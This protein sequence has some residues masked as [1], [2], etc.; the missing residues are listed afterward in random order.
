MCSPNLEAL[1]INC[2]L[3]YSPREFSSFIPV[4]VYVPPDACVSTAMQQ[5]AE[6]ISEMEQRYPDSLLIILGD[7]NKANLS[8]EMLKYSQ[9]ITCPPEIIGSLL[10]N[11]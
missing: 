9:H 3:F 2:K 8:R 6:Q 11:N 1:F 10:H 7:F 5:L 4:N